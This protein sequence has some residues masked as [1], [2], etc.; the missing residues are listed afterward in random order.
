MKAT[1]MFEDLESISPQNTI[2]KTELLNILKKYCK[3][4]SPYDL[5][6]ATA[7]M[8]EEGKYVQANYREK[9]L[10]VYVKY[11]IMRVKEILDNNNYLDAPIDKESFNESFNLLK[12][13]FEKERNYDDKFPLIYIIVSL[14]TTFIL[15]EPIHPVG[16]EFPGSLKVEKKEGVFYCPVKDKQKDNKN[17]IC[18]LCLAKQTPGI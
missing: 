8:R 16:S 17:T 18:N 7:R 4:I 2:T 13:Q 1:D 6:L 5:M 3:I 9:Y 11:F 14:Y 15:E 10:E 12:Y